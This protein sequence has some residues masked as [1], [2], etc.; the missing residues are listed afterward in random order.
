M[1]FPH[2]VSFFSEL[3][4]LTISE[5]FV[6]CRAILIGQFSYLNHPIDKLSEFS[7]P[8]KAL[9]YFDTASKFLLFYICFS[10]SVKDSFSNFWVYLS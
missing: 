8:D 9:N 5:F 1:L 4:D 2:L 3:T 7:S 10:I 6:L